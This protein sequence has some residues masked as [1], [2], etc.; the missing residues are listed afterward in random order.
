MNA[1]FSWDRSARK[2]V[3]LYHRAIASRIPRPDLEQYHV[4][5]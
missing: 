1:N 5:S 4:P 2:Y 3:D